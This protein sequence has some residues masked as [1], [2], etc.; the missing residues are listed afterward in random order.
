MR[1]S[2]KKAKNV[3]DVLDTIS[4]GQDSRDW[5]TQFANDKEKRY[6]TSIQE[7]ILNNTKSYI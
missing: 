4:K 3:S 6:N 1:S 7:L 2:L 5:F